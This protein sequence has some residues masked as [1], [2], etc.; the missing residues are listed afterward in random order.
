MPRFA[1]NLTMMYNEH[2]FLERFAAAARDG[3]KA[4]EYLFPYEFPAAELKARLDAHGLVQALFNAPP[5][6]WAAGERGIAS[7]PGREDEFRR[8]IDTA[9]DY[10]RVI[11]NDTL[12]VMAGLIAPTQDRARHRD[13]YLRNLAHA[14]EA[15]RAQNVTIVIEPINPRDM[16]GFFLNRQDDAQA[17]CR[18]VGAP[19]LLVQFD[20]YHCQIVEGDLAMKLTRDIA[21]IGHIQIAGVPQRHEPDVGEI[22]YPYLFELI[23]AL[24]YDG[25]IGC[26]YRPKA[27]TSE[28]LGW[29]APYL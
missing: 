15:A 24:G 13:V 28:G 7:L 8:A 2:A 23:D 22:H 4:V 1:A 26:E 18:E 27:G 16:P 19:N 14:A 20:C 6:D 25:W 21:G 11:G 12:H 3:F 29:L 5:G 9:L 10:A 17:I